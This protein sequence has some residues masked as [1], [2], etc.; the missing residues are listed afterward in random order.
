[1]EP[2]GGTPTAGLTAPITGYTPRPSDRAN[3]ANSGFLVLLD[4]YYPGWQ[5]YIDGQRGTII[6]A[7]YF[8]RAVYLERGEHTVRFVYR[9]LSFYGGLALAGAGL[10]VLATA[11]WLARRNRGQGKDLSV[12]KMVGEFE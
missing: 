9:P 7:D 11:A 10:S 12:Q 4:S 1:M 8:A 3:L 2:S 6:R 5:V